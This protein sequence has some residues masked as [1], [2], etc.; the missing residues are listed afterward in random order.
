MIQ[1]SM[2][3]YLM[4]MKLVYYSIFN[5]PLHSIELRKFTVNFA[6]YT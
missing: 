2:V 3:K 4:S 1:F 6:L 5:D